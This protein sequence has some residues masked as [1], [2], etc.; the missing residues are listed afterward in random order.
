MRH[1]YVLPQEGAVIDLRAQPQEQCEM[2]QLTD[3]SGEVVYMV[4]GERS[5]L[6]PRA[7]PGKPG[8]WLFLEF[9]CIGDGIPLCLGF[10]CLIVTRIPK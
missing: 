3:M 10:F 4:P 6:L 5:A 8:S 2:S 1:C 9:V 7:M